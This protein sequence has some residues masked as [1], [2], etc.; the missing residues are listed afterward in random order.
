VPSVA[1]QTWKN[2]AKVALDEIA[3]AHAA[4]GGQG[5]GRRYATQE[6]NHAYAVLLSSQFQRFCRD[7]HT[8]AAAHVVDA[9]TPVALR[10][11]VRARMLEARKLDRGNPNP[12]NLGADFGRFG[13]DFWATVRA[14]NARNVRRQAAL[15]NL[16]A[17]RNAIAHQDFPP[18]LTPAPP[19][20]LGTVR[21][22]RSACSALATEFDHVVAAQLV[23][24]VGTRPW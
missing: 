22:W 4:V 23:A 15:E 14:R 12:S 19:L 21:G 6:I 20:H 1:L 13:F 11:V 17:W 5:P 24:L 18:A 2:T 9:V 16:S 10:P 7:L 8:E 3:A